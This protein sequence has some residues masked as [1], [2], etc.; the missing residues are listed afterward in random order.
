MHIPGFALEYQVAEVEGRA[1]RLPQP[2]QGGYLRHTDA[3]GR[4]LCSPSGARTPVPREHWPPPSAD[5]TSDHAFD[6]I[7]GLDALVGACEPVLSQ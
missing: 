7:N 3:G 6:Q 1:H 4:M 2:C 5:V